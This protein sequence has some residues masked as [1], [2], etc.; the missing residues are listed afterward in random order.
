MIAALGSLALLHLLMALLPGPNTL[1]VMHLAVSRSRAAGLAAAGGV[2]LGSAIWVTVALLGFAVL[3]ARAGELYRLLQLAGALYLMFVGSRMI[4]SGLRRPGGEPGPRLRAPGHAP[5]LR[6]LATTLANPKS[7]VFWSSVF[8]VALPVSA[9]AWFAP[10]VVLIVT[11]QAFAWYGFCA[12]AC[13][14]GPV[15]AVP[16]RI[17]RGLDVLAGGIMLV[18]G[19]RLTWDLARAPR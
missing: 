18:L 17:G 8:L 11:V 3:M 16:A 12:L 19:G 10:A 15:R 4:L 6:G 2:A 1:L 5:L 7:A 13:S 9:P 14:T